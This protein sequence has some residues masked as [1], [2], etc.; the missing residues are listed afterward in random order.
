MKFVFEERPGDSPLV[1]TIW[2]NHNRDAGL[3]TSVALSHWEMV[4]TKHEGKTMLTVRGPE[5]RA[6]PAYCP[7][8]AEHFAIMFKFGT[9]MPHLP[10]S[11]LLDTAIDLPNATSKSFWLHGSAWEFP[12]F[13]N[14]DVFVDRL[15]RQGMLV[16]EPVVESTLLGRLKDL[17]L[18][19]AQRR[20][21]RATGLTHSAVRQIERARYA[22][23]LLEQGMSILDTVY[24]A[25]YTDQPY[26]TRMLKH[27]I[28]KTP[29]QLV[30]KSPP[31]Q[32]SF[33]FKTPPL[34]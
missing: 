18:R 6:T 8:D 11:N 22:A 31:E 27:L 15:I 9:F 5:T 2:R 33:L 26:L 14:A 17:S 23:T 32:L 7:A 13:D 25:G 21:L 24:E 34:S 28:G 3:F 10:G 20:F 19:S 4:V 29:A 12:T 1:E 16:R 30:A